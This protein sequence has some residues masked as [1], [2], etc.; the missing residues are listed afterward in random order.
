[1]GKVIKKDLLESLYYQQGLSF[2]AIASYVGCSKTNIRYY[3]NKYGLTARPRAVAIILKRLIRIAKGRNSNPS[4]HNS[5]QVLEIPPLGL[6]GLFIPLNKGI[7]TAKI[8]IMSQ[9]I[10][11]AMELY[12]HPL[13]YSPDNR[14][15]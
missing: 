7:S 1:M 2:N 4:Y 14:K 6:Y 12:S 10:A 3:F 11:L 15:Q 8:N 9:I 13:S 5:P